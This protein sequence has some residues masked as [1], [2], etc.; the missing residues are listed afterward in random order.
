MAGAICCEV[1]ERIWGVTQGEGFADDRECPADDNAED[2]DVVADGFGGAAGCFVPAE[3]DSFGEPENYGA[4]EC[5]AT[6]V[7]DFDGG[8]EFHVEQYSRRLVKVN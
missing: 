4:S 8:F 7:I 6:E 2:G 3:G 5:M 1:L